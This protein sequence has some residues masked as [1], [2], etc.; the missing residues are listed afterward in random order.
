MAPILLMGPLTLAALASHESP[1]P[2]PL[3]IAL[4]VMWVAFFYVWFAFCSGRAELGQKWLYAK[5]AYLVGP[6]I[7]ICLARLAGAEAWRAGGWFI[8]A[9]STAL[10]PVLILKGKA[11]RRRPAV[12]VPTLV[13]E[14]SRV[15]AVLPIMFTKDANA[16][17][18]SG[19]VAGAVVFGWTLAF[20]CKMPAMGIAMVVLSAFGRMYWRAHHFLDVSVGGVIAVVCCACLSRFVVDVDSVKWWHPVAAHV[21]LLGFMI[22]AHKKVKH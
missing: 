9:W 7:G 14:T 21:C 13:P 8:V 6:M 17:F 10:V 12:C 4:F 22:Q 5:A 16:S 11:K 3:W 20:A 1:S 19:D 2:S 15:I 18:P